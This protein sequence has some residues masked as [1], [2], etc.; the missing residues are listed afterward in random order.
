MEFLK[1]S[2][3]TYYEQRALQAKVTYIIDVSDHLNIRA[4]DATNETDDF[5]IWRI[6]YHTDRLFHSHYAQGLIFKK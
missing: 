4:M 5:A 2:L 3:F 1:I 6:V